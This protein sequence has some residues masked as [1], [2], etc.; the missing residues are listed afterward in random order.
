MN[1]WKTPI[2]LLPPP[3][4]AT[5]ASGSRPVSVEH[6]LARLHADDPLEVADHHRERVRAADEPMQ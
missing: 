2:A 5:T 6:L 1:A 3:T 4:Q